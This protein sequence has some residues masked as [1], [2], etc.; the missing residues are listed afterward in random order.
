MTAGDHA[1]A[2]ANMLAPQG[3]KRI[4]FAGQAE[5]M[6]SV[7]VVDQLPASQSGLQMSTKAGKQA[8]KKGK[9]KRSEAQARATEKQKS[10][11]IAA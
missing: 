9:R 1:Q 7:L 4:A 11:S 2:V 5:D 6:T 10:K 8:E 3:M